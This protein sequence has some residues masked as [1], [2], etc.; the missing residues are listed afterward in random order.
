[1]EKWNKKILYVGLILILIFAI[2]FAFLTKK[3]NKKQIQVNLSTNTWALAD[4]WITTSTWAE[5]PKI[6]EN[7]KNNE[8]LAY[9][10]SFIWTA[11]KKNSTNTEQLADWMTIEVNDSIITWADWEAEIIFADNSVIRLNKN[12]TLAFT[13][14][15]KESTETS[16]EDWE[17]W[18]RILK[19]IFDKT[20]FSIKTSDISAW[21]R[22][23]SVIINKNRNWTDL[24][25]IDSYS[26]IKWDEWVIV[27]LLTK[28]NNPWKDIIVKPENWIK[29]LKDS[30]I[31][32]IE[33]FKTK[34][35]LLQNFIR[36]NTSKDIVYMD[37]LKKK[38]VN[39]ND[40]KNK[41]Q[42]ELL[43]SLPTKDE[44]RVF[45]KEKAVREKV[46]R[47]VNWWWTIN[48]NAIIQDVKKENIIIWTRWKL[49][50]NKELLRKEQDPNKKQQIERVI[51]QEEELLNNTLKL[52]MNNLNEETLPVRPAVSPLQQK[53]VLPAPLPIKPAPVPVQPAPIPAPAPVPVQ[54]APTPSPTPLP[55][56]PIMSDETSIR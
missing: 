1:M 54:P 19:P 17:I 16:L 10:N 29:V 22:W 12:T 13:K 45:F 6:I 26:K 34:D 44:V 38:I 39:D 40:L 23:T 31:P 24:K 46:Q 42:W 18:V 55:K 4:S 52:I 49:N 30:I 32:K 28:K 3:N 15:D 7:I 51:R 41:I 5:T 47:Y 33:S 53:P 9:V 48:P 36:D 37:D 56:P 43:Q 21:V 20:F 27:K 25:V 8:P 2:S 11:S 50:I 35:I 14:L